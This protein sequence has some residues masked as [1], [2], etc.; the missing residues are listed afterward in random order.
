MLADLAERFE[1]GAAC[2]PMVPHEPSGDDYAFIEDGACLTVTIVDGVGH[3]SL[4]NTAARAAIESV[5]TA[6]ARAPGMELADLMRECHQA[7]RGTQGA[8]VGICRFDPARSTTSYLGVGNTGFLR[9]PGRSG[10]GV[11]LPGIVGFRMRTLR[12]FSTDLVPGDIYAFHTDGVSKS[13]SPA[14]YLAGPVDASARRALAEHG[15]INDDAAVVLVR[16]R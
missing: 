11:S 16:F 9:H 1:I 14:D 5:T 3:G 13:F 15:K 8:A 10:P 4:A 6:L 2:R 12:I 7:L